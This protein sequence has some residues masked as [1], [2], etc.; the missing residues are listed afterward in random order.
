[1]CV[2]SSTEKTRHR[3]QHRLLQCLVSP[4]GSI[5]A[6][7]TVAGALVAGLALSQAF[8]LPGT[9]PT[10]SA[11]P[12]ITDLFIPPDGGFEACS[13]CHQDGSEA[14]FPY[15][16]WQGSMMA[17]AARDPLFYAQ[18]DLAN[19]DDSIR[20]QVAGMGDMCLRCHSP[21]AWLEGR[22]SDPVDPTDHSGMSFIQ[23]DLFGVQCHACHR[24]VDPEVGVKYPGHVDVANILN[25]LGTG[26][27]NNLWP[28]TYGNGMFV[29]DPLHSR[30]GPYDLSELEDHL[31]S[32]LEESP[33]VSWADAPAHFHPVMDSPFHREGNICGTC[34]DVSN[35]TDCGASTNGDTQDCFPIE[36]TWTEWRHSAFYDATAPGGG[37]AKNCQSCHMSG[38]LNAVNFGMPCVGGGANPFP[39]FDDVHFHDLTGGN[40]FIPL[41]LK[42]MK[43][44]YN[45][46]VADPMCAGAELDF[47]NAVD[48][49]YPPAGGS[50]FLFMQD[51]DL[52]AGV[53]RVKRTL[54]R[55]AYLDV[56]SVTAND[57]TVRVT[58]RT[59]HKLP[60]GYPEGRR[61][62]L[63][64]R[65]LNNVGALVAESGRYNG[66][67]DEDPVLE[68]AALY[69]DQSVDGAVGPKP[70]DV[71]TYTDAA[72][73]ALAIGRPTKVWEGRV[74]YDPTGTC[75][76]DPMVDCIEFH[77]ALNN[78][79]VMDNRI[80]PEG[81]D[82][83]GYTDNRAVPV[84]PAAYTA[85]GWQGDYGLS[86]GPTIHWDDVVYARPASIDR[87]E[88]TLY[89]QTASREYIEA[90]NDDNPGTFTV[91]GYHRGSLMFEE[92][93]R[94]G[95]S[96][97]VPMQRL[98]W[99]LEDA[100]NDGLSD[101]WEA[102]HGLAASPDGGA[103]DDP[104]GDGFSN[105]QE[106]QLGSD[107]VPPNGGDDP[108]VGAMRDPV[109]L[110]LVLDKSGSMNGNAPDT[111]T[112][113]MDVLQDAA[114]LLLNTWKEYAVAG[115]RLGIVWFD[116]NVSPAPAA[117]SI[118]DFITGLPGALTDID[119][120]T[121]GG[122][123]AMGA[124]L[125]TA[126]EELVGSPN[127]KH[128]VL[129]SNGMQNRSPMIRENMAGDLVIRDQVVADPDVT[130]GSNVNLG[131]VDYALPN[132]VA[133]HTVGIGV[134]GTNSSGDGWHELL[135]ELAEEQNGKHNFVTEAYQLEGVFLEDLVEALRGNTLEYIDQQEWFLEMGETATFE[136]PVNNSATK[137][138]A[139]VS[140][141][142]S[143]G[144]A[145]DLELIR[146]DGKKEDHTRLM[147]Q[148]KFF[149]IV[150]RSLEDFDSAERDFG[151]WKLRITHRK[152]DN[153]RRGKLRVRAHGLLD[154]ARLEY[155]FRLPR[156]GVRVGQPLRVAAGVTF[157]KRIYTRL[158]Q[159]Q[160]RLDSPSVS[161]AGLLARSQHKP[162]E[163]L[164][165]DKDGLAGPYTQKLQA[166]LADKDWSAQLK[167]QQKTYYL[168]DKSR[169]GDSGAGNGGLYEKNLMTLKVPGHYRLHFELRGTAPT[170]EPFVRE[171]TRSVV[172]GI[173][174]LERDKSAPRLQDDR[175]GDY[176]VFRPVDVYGNLLGPGHRFQ[177][178][179]MVEKTPLAIEDLLDGSYRVKLPSANAIEELRLALNG[180]FFYG[181]QRK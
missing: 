86:G 39:H 60:T 134:A 58:N 162:G 126:L 65:F 111:S 105:W 137:F 53:E 180:E 88:L 67:G 129:F 106:F 45:T 54:K 133:V 75:H 82:V 47:K 131:G 164:D 7:A 76:S 178:N 175:D 36:R 150:S 84:I 52:D 110:I 95:K 70:Y 155:L 116:T 160:V 176:A 74:D 120:Q 15:N 11:E 22:S 174:K 9:Q 93:Q 114:T 165:I 146:P 181:K 2:K 104:D 30:R 24:L 123:T 27:G 55:A 101:G 29:M 66:D 127:E 62:W 20:P 157:G 34:H 172:V 132:D 125:H 156:G 97:P 73:T 147:R 3:R 166:A 138:S 136:I 144:P 80:P 98:V 4:R 40:A 152:Q 71:L 81:W 41:V 51:N 117:F 107:P 46:C 119:T 170:G 109:D 139:V 121:A 161:L 100:D 57:L 92:W 21:V 23:K 115:D 163:R 149:R 118:S 142:G 94:N 90:L 151:L 44:R 18:L 140:W 68:D 173:G 35:P 16:P 96:Q 8:H 38:P 50:P 128:V 14:A 25:T 56:T 48:G 42:D 72:G 83:T 69:H 33:M 113:K 49:L 108:E 31:A 17:Q 122:W 124:G 13:S 102:Q 177:L 143:P 32:V 59:G 179:A 169:D 78:S 89:Y 148:G 112:P 6:S 91:A 158:D 145:P 159:I 171:E 28:P 12:S 87:V 153:G 168:K 167:T 135:H 130:G 77:F 19:S 43:N 1:M 85:A 5:I 99:A 61:M 103:N 79:V 10:T 26:P 37:E 63:N 64:V 141:S 154:D